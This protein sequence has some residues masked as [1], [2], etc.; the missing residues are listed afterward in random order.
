MPARSAAGAYQNW[1]P[2]DVYIPRGKEE[3][4]THRLY[5]L[6]APHDRYGTGFIL[7]G[8]VMGSQHCQVAKVGP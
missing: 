6:A 8:A 1:L 7:V 3:G 5:A 4:R 2:S